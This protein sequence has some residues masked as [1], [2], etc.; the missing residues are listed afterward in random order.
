MLLFQVPPPTRYDL[1]FTLAGFPIRVHPL[2][3]LITLLFGSTGDLLLIPIWI[4]VIFVSIVVHELGHALAFRRFGLSSQIVLH[5]MGGLTI[6]QST[7]WGS[8]WANVALS[9]N[10]NIFISVAGPGAGFL[11]AVLVIVVVL[12]V[13]GSVGTTWLLG[14]IPLPLTAL[15]PFGGRVVNVMVS[16]LLWVNVFWGLINLLPVYPLDGGNVTRNILIQADP[17][18]GVR[19]SLWI[20]VITGALIALAGLLVFRS[21]FM[22]L[23]FGL[24]AFQSYQSLQGR[25]YQ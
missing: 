6:P 17:V 24:L 22:A 18:D 11:L 9:P 2:F 7:L 14:F 25:F 3:W 1:N 4:L 15:V 12:L 8:R 10:Q 21:I 16:L 13:G 19:K 5:G 20:S 23:L